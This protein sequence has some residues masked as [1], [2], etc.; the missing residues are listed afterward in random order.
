MD[1]EMPEVS[2]FELTKMIRE[3]YDHWFSIIFLSSDDRKV[4]SHMV[5]I[6]GDDYLTEPAKEEIL[7]A[8]IRAMGRIARMQAELDDLNHQLEVL[9]HID[10]LT[11]LMN[12]RGLDNYMVKK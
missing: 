1:I 11:Q 12:R 7:N 3:Q 2:G 4:A 5:L 6:P 8:K 9:S 10:P